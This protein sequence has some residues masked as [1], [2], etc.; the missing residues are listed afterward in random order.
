MKEMKKL[1]WCAL[2]PCLIVVFLCGCEMKEQVIMDITKDKKVSVSTVA[3]MDDEMIDQFIKMQQSDATESSASDEEITD[4]QRWAYLESD[5]DSETANAEEGKPE[6]YDDG[7]H[8]GLKRTKEPVKLDELV[9]E[10]PDTPRANVFAET[11]EIE[12][13]G[14]FK[15][16]K[17]YVSNLCATFEEGELDKIKQNSD[18]IS[19]K[20]EFVVTL[21]SKPLSHNATSV[22]EDGKTLT[23]DFSTME[24]QNIDFTFKDPGAFPWLIVL[25]C[26]IILL[27]L[28]VI[29]FAI[30]QSSKNRK[31]EWNESGEGSVIDQSRNVGFEGAGENLGNVDL[32]GNVQEVED[33][34][35]ETVQEVADQVSEKA[36]ETEDRIPGEDWDQGQDPDS[37]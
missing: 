15:K 1:V 23:W 25:G 3:A 31:K 26:L 36:L 34:V 8:K 24:S 14:F 17:N 22:S 19:I 35:S 29:I 20:M 10:S 16:G 4:E 28:A 32:A 33:Q 5:A 30:I 37:E 2:L 27:L 18:K 11:P 12:K 7:T 6:R 9:A 13:A 21:P